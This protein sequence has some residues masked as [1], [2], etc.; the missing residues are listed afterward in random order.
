MYISYMPIK[1]LKNFNLNIRA[2]SLS[3]KIDAKMYDF[4]TERMNIKI[5][6]MNG[7]S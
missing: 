1:Y 3:K 7:T 6:Q 4:K 2:N 5:K